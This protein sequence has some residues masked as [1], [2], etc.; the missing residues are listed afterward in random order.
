M[1]SLEPGTGVFALRYSIW[2]DGSANP[3]GRFMGAGWVVETEQGVKRAFQRSLAEYNLGS[4]DIAEILSATLALQSVPLKSDITLFTDSQNLIRLFNHVSGIDI[5]RN[6]SSQRRIKH[7]EALNKLFSLAFRHQS[8]KMQYASAEA[9]DNLQQAH[10]NARAA[11]DE[12]EKLSFPQKKAAPDFIF[13]TKL[14][15][16]SPVPV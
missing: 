14:P 15:A 1:T 4:S 3:V 16:I 11:S 12:A 13:E 7:Q 6:T 9:D 8:V 10:D 5:A 2:S